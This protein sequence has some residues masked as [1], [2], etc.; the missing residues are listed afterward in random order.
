M[1]IIS[2]NTAIIS[3]RSLLLLL[4][5]LYSSSTTIHQVLAISNAHRCRRYIIYTQHL[6]LSNWMCLYSI[7][8][9]RWYCQ[10]TV[11]YRVLCIST[12]HRNLLPKHKGRTCRGRSYL[13][14]RFTARPNNK[15]RDQSAHGPSTLSIRS[16]QANQENPPQWREYLNATLWQQ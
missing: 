16:T 15:I 9:S 7:N 10:K 14:R 1:E 11:S 5:L 13:F 3:V 8:T 6:W 2:T 4:L 12:L